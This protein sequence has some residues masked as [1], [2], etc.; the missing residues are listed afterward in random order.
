MANILNDNFL[1]ML[2]YSHEKVPIYE[3]A[4]PIHQLS[5]SRKILS[6]GPND[7]NR[8]FFSE[9]IH[10]SETFVI[11]WRNYSIIYFFAILINTFYK[12]IIFVSF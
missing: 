9:K 4:G 1:L 2:I 6:T 5:H 10:F 3:Q 8:S 7:I 12:N 11:L